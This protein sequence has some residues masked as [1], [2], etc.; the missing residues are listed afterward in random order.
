MHVCAPFFEEIESRSQYE[1]RRCRQEKEHRCT[2]MALGDHQSPSC[3]PN[4]RTQE[5]D[6]E[7]PE[8]T[9]QGGRSH[10]ESR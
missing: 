5:Q 4:R 9:K 10:S 8:V 3:S 2:Q 7:G 6:K 1:N